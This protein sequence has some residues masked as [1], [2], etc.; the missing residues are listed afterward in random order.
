MMHE[1]TGK[2]ERSPKKSASHNSS[3]PWY[4]DLKQFGQLGFS[5]SFLD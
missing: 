2:E 5:L 4:T 3:G 1:S